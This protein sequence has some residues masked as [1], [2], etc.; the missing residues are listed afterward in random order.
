ML[1]TDDAR[2]IRMPP[3]SAAMFC[4]ALKVLLAT[5]A[6]AAY[7]PGLAGPFLFDDV[8]NLA[9]LGRYG[10][11]R[12]LDTFAWFLT[13]GIADPTGRPVAQLSF[14]IDAR[15]WP[16]DPWAFKRTNL[17]LHLLNGLL[18]YSVLLA[19]GRRV[20]D[21]RRAA[22]AALLGAGLWL[23]HPLWT[24]TVLYVVQ[25]QAILATL[26]V[27]AGIRAW[28]AGQ[29]AFERGARARGWT[30]S[31]LAV[32]VFGAL[33]GLSK[34][35]GFLLPTL[36]AVLQVTVLRPAPAQRH[37]NVGTGARWARVALVW[38]PTFL[39][40][41]WLAW[42]AAGIGLDGHAGRPWTLGQRLLSQPRALCDY[43]WRL[44][45]PGLD[46][47]G[48][49]ADGFVLSRGWT[50][51]ATTLPA[52]VAVMALAYAAWWSR[53]RAPVF[54]A[55]AGLFLAGH[56]MESSVVMLEL[57]FEHRNYLPAVM[58]FWPLAWWLAALGRYRSLL[59][60]GG[61]AYLVLMLA[62]TALQAQLWAD[63][64][65]LARAWASQNPSSPRAQVHAASVEVAA[66]DVD[67]AERR[68][69]LAVAARP[70]DP[71][72]AIGL[73]DLRCR[74]QQVRQAD[75]DRAAAA[76]RAGGGV[77]L[78]M[79]HQW[80]AATLQPASGAACAGLQTRALAP[81]VRAALDTGGSARVSAVETSA[82]IQRVSAYAALREGDCA[83]ASAAFV[84]QNAL[85]PRPEFVDDQVHVLARQC[86]RVAAARHLH[87]YIEA[88]TPV[89]AAPSLP[90]RL[91][92]R[93]TAGLW[94]R[95][96]RDL[97][98]SL[99]AAGGKMH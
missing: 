79:V 26:F 32:P 89:A 97:A 76:I 8:A 22:V 35:N 63:P 93:L 12:D 25:R 39:V 13:S 43:L 28:I 23:L 65:A 10:G 71:Q 7:W 36:L 66:G 61:A 20:G 5:A 72:S 6:A 68:L 81:L 87:G 51:P 44:F 90:L 52:A 62:A 18:L 14:L 24:S 83:A 16:A 54:A 56:A 50:R 21:P 75:L 69:A 94:S 40:L 46:A 58:L 19:L 9:A 82:R 47:T 88:G 86:G 92:D 15:D 38:A 33:A 27:L 49:F 1:L 37:G 91:R 55:A 95:H 57:Y 85:Q 42:H 30:W 45:V 48:I 34:A 78:D 74:R 4:R 80:M 2:L 67:A 31:V 60:A 99:E 53:R 98:A 64:L 17:V 73:L 59:L 96:W 3:D 11:V 84:R 41:A 70:R 77:G 29:Q